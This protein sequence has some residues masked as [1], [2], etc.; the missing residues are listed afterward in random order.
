[1]SWPI[2]DISDSD[3]LYFFVH[4]S[5][6]EYDHEDNAVLKEAALTDTPLN[7]GNKSCDWSRYASAEQTRVL[8]GRQYKT[9]KTE[10]KNPAEFFVFSH[11]VEQWRSLHLRFREFPEQRVE[12]NPI[13]ENPEPIGF[14]NNRAHAIIIGDKSDM[15]LRV[16]MARSAQWEVKPP[17]TKAEM[18]AYR[19][20]LEE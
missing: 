17:A 5:K 13:E 20:E 12:H 18:K 3:S 10:F 14:P 11:G 8:L 15:R 16:A 9:G 1:M 6:V 19:R 4:H 2:E 7:G